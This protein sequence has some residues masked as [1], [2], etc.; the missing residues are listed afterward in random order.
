MPTTQTTA[1]NPPFSRDKSLDP[2]APSGGWLTQVQ[3]LHPM[4]IIDTSAGSYSENVPPAGSNSTT[5]LSN[6]NQELTFKKVSADGNTFTLNASSSFPE[7]PLTLTAQYS[8]FKIK[9]D[10]TKW[11]VT[12]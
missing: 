3:V 5:G 4:R 12:G 11:Y 9:S 2:R 6:Q 10:G 1:P 8:H 7:G